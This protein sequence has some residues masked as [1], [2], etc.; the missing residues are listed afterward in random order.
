MVKGQVH[1]LTGRWFDFARL[2]VSKG[3]DFV[4]HMC[5]VFQGSRKANRGKSKGNKL[6]GVPSF[7]YV[8]KKAPKWGGL[9]SGFHLDTS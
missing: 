7:G 1:V 6:L 9:S 4:G 3:S 8:W 2:L 5:M